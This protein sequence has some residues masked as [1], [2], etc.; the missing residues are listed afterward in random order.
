[1]FKFKFYQFNYLKN[2]SRVSMTHWYRQMTHI[3]L[4]A[5]I[6]NQFPIFLT[7]FLETFNLFDS[8]S[9]KLDICTSQQKTFSWDI[10][11]FHL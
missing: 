11:D 1:M 3:L 8:D 5:W 2:V 7:I 9:Y 4:L 10:I 6:D